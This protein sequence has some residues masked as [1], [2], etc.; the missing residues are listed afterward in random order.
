MRASA[1]LGCACGYRARSGIGTRESLRIANRD[2]SERTWSQREELRTGCPGLGDVREHEGLLLGSHTQLRTW[3]HRMHR[4]KRK[5]RM[6]H[7]GEE[8]ARGHVVEVAESVLGWG[9][10]AGGGKR[11]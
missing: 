6:P 8:S 5:Q 7:N 1:G 2:E 10:E 11:R 9:K 4:Q 3:D